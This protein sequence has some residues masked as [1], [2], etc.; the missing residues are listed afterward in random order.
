MN[1]WNSQK[2]RSMDR[3]KKLFHGTS[4]DF[5]DPKIIQI[6]S[7]LQYRAIFCGDMSLHTSKAGPWNIHWIMSSMRFCHQQ[8]ITKTLD[9]TFLRQGFVQDRGPLRGLG[10]QPTRGTWIRGYHWGHWGWGKAR[11]TDLEEVPWLSSQGETWCT[12]PT[13]AA[14]YAADSHDFQTD[15]CDTIV[16]HSKM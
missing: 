15:V 3:E 16:T 4:W 5:Q 10:I 9:S 11:L 14:S 1:Q 12:S 7:S 6:G 2:Q 13:I 8:K